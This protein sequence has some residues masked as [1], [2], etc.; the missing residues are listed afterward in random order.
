MGLNSSPQHTAARI[1]RPPGHGKVIPL[2]HATGV[3]VEAPLHSWRSCRGIGQSRRRRMSPRIATM[4]A[5][6]RRRA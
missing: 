5:V 1:Q 2:G 3:R 6:P 4:T